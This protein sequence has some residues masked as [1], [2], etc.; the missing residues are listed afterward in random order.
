MLN[1][2]NT[3]KHQINKEYLTMTISQ[4]DFARLDQLIDIIGYTKL[5]V[6]LRDKQATCGGFEFHAQYVRTCYS[7]QYNKG[8]F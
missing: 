6:Q 1:I 8:F 3:D 7:L 2:C 4:D 5:L